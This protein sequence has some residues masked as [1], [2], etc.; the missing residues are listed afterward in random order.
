MARDSIEKLLGVN[1]YDGLLVNELHFSHADQRSGYLFA[2][3]QRAFM[4]Q[5]G[6]I[7]IDTTAGSHVRP[8]EIAEV[9]HQEQ[10]VEISFKLPRTL[11]AVT[12]GGQLLIAV[13]TTEKRLGWPVPVLKVVLSKDKFT[14]GEY[15]VAARPDSQRDLKI[16]HNVGRSA[17]P[18][19][20]GASSETIELGYPAVALELVETSQYKS[21]IHNTFADCVALG[22]LDNGGHEIKLRE[23]HVPPLVRLGLARSF[24]ADIDDLS[25]LFDTLVAETSRR[26]TEQYKTLRGEFDA[27]L[28]FKAMA[29]LVLRTF[30]LTKMGL[31]RNMAR[32]SAAELFFEVMY[33]IAEWHEQYRARAYGEE[34]LPKFFAIRPDIKGLTW[35]DLC[36]DSGPLLARSLEQLQLLSEDLELI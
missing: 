4:R 36:V 16:D 33:P 32:I 14:P 10:T 5:P 23:D 6:I 7:D 9:N 21:N 1:W 20:V 15:V 24:G 8:V 3:A 25:Q 19:V 29:I 12:P 27:E 13:Q 11:K 26:Q 17:D 35:E 34:N 18:A 28:L 2:E 31:I 30:L 22:L